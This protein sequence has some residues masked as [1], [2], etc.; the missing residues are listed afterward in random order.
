[1]IGAVI[2]LVIGAIVQFQERNNASKPRPE[3]ARKSTVDS[4]VNSS[5]NSPAAS[6]AKSAAAEL[7]GKVVSVHDGDTVT[8][9]VAGNRQVRIRLY[10]IDTPESAQDFGSRA[11][12]FTSIQCAGKTVRVVERDRDHYDRMVGEVFVDGESLNVALVRAGMAWWYRRHAKDYTA[13]EDAE[14][15]AKRNRRGLWSQPNPTPPW[16]WRR[17]N[18]VGNRK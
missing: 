9:L 13:L 6:S 4:S 18:N 14:A 17:L 3:P 16:D 7:T 8:V 11:K 5:A 15:D 1:M 12:Q 10:G 2:A